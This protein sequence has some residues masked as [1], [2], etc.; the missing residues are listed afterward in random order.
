MAERIFLMFDYTSTGLWYEGADGRP[1]GTV[2]PN[3]LS[4]SKSTKDRLA[5]WV[6]RLDDLNTQ[7]FTGSGPPPRPSS[8]AAARREGVA[9][10][11]AIREEAGPEWTVGIDT[12]A[13]VVWDEADL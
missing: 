12:D 11:H 5:A 6:Q 2:D 8:W 7:E 10:W 9:I 1:A 4:L 3:D 13:G